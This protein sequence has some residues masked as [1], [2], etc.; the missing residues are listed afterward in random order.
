MGVVVYGIFASL[1]EVSVKV[2]YWAIEQIKKERRRQRNEGRREAL[3]LVLTKLKQDPNASVEDIRKA[4]E[5]SMQESEK[6]GTG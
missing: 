3:D 6:N 1:V 4:V 2:A 5:T